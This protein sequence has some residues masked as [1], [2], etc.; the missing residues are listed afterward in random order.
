MKKKI[1]MRLWKESVI[2]NPY[3]RGVPVLSFPCVSLM[4]I[5]VKELVDSSDL[6]AQGMKMIADRCPSLAALSMMN[7]TVEAEAFGA[8]V[9]ITENEIPSVIGALV[10][11]VETAENLVV[12]DPCTGRT[13]IYIDAMAKACELITD[14][15]V[16]AGIIGPFT[17]AG[18]MIGIQQ[19]LRAVKKNPEMLR[20]TLRKATDF[21]IAYAKAYKELTG[22]NGFV[23]AEPLTGLLSPKMAED[24]SESYVKEIIDAVQDE[25]FIC[26]Y[27]NCGDNAVYMADSIARLG[28]E[29]YHFGNIIKMSDILPKLPADSLVMGNIDPAQSFCMGTP[30]GM[31]KEVKELMEECYSYPNFVISSGCDIAPIANWDCIDSFYQ[32]IDEFYTEKGISFVP[33]EQTV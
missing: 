4:G 26:I 15:P 6:Q 11:S 10:T 14:R 24:F 20:V 3:K 9:L 25:E 18:R 5:S 19:T 21:I 22:A 7:L 1:N 17:L 8:E 32:A 29:G 23:M 16:F 28:A 2:R 27:H 30:E 12:P 13:K 33:Y 31:N